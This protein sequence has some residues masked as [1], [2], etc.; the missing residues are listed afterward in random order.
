MIFVSERLALIELAAPAV[1]LSLRLG[2]LAREHVSKQTMRRLALAPAAGL[3]GIVVLFGG[4][5]YF[6][7]WRFY[8]DRFNS[9]ADFTLW[10]LS[11]YYTTSHNNGVMAMKQRGVWPMPYYTLE[12][13]WRFPLVAG[14]SF[15]YQALNGF[16]PEDAHRDTLERFGTVELNN[17]G[18][19][20]MPAMDYDWPG[21]LLY[22][23]AFGF[24]AGRLHR[25]FM[26]GSFVGLA[27]YP[28]VFLSM[29]EVPRLLYLSSVR[30]FPTLVLLGVIA[31]IEARR[32]N[33]AAKSTTF[34]SGYLR[35]PPP[36]AERQEALR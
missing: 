7:S 32:T 25:S 30:S 21:Y 1:V 24:V 13:F 19:L 27:F 34:A 5:E 11:G 26:A 29:M 3:V 36:S 28:L 33:R 14:S 20:F 16:D 31:A 10:R 35:T 8:E 18:G 17:P 6:R 12:Q 9:L 22:W 2:T 15:S 4:A 23:C